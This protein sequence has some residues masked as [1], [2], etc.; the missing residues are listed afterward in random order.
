MNG[1][2]SRWARRVAMAAVLV[3][4]MAACTG[5]GES[6]GGASGGSSLDGRDPK[7]LVVARGALDRGIAPA[8][9]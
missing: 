3:L 8:R 7:T 4:T 2:R 1:Q 6:S 5:T 9:A